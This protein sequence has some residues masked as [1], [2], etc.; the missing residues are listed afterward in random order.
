[1]TCGLGVLRAA[2]E[3]L[4]TLHY[5]LQEAN[6]SQYCEAITAQGYSCALDVAE[7][8]PEDLEQLVRDLQLR[9]FEGMRLM[10][11]LRDLHEDPSKIPH[12]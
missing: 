5:L 12:Y 4:G 10:R 7:A 1:M 11:I 3:P 9:P 6:L 8:A 2:G